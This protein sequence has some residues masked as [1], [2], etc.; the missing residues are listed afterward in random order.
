MA[1]SAPNI[2][3]MPQTTMPNE[4]IGS[5]KP[6][7]EPMNNEA[8]KNSAIELQ[9]TKLPV[10]PSVPKIASPMKPNV[11]PSNKPTLKDYLDAMKESKAS[12]KDVYAVMNDLPAKIQN[13][14]N[15]E[16]PQNTTVTESQDQKPEN[17]SPTGE[18]CLFV[19]WAASSSKQGQI[20][21][22]SL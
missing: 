10:A 14:E 21:M 16:P 11:V 20:P 5:W 7:N 19:T 13:E 8:A 9:K 4:S 3:P 17:V 1:P 15:V 18:F 6:I 22:P 2:M 12:A